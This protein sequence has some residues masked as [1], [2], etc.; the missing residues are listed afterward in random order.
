MLLLQDYSET[1]VKKE[2]N[3]NMSES[4]FSNGFFLGLIIG[5]G[6][7]FLLGTKTGKKILKTMSE[8]GLE[9]V[10]NFIEEMDLENPDE[11]EF[12]DEV[13]EEMEEE[14]EK[15]PE[16]VEEKKETSNAQSKTEDKVS[17]KK[18]FFKKIKH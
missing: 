8:E 2:K 4:R 18:R 3:N 12:Q 9:G 13:E 7:V 10:T 15:N 6:L 14:G 5:G 16:T 1:E 11:E 17:P